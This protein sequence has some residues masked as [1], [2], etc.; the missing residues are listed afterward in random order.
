HWKAPPCHGAHVKRS[1]ATHVGDTTLRQAVRQKM[2]GATV[3][4]NDRVLADPKLTPRGYCIDSQCSG[5]QLPPASPPTSTHL[6]PIPA[7][8]ISRPS[9]PKLR[10]CVSSMLA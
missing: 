6:T 7:I 5:S 8:S 10:F 9:N 2:E 3:W 4:E 1:S